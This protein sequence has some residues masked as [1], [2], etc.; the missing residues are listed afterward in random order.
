VGAVGLRL[1]EWLAPAALLFAAEVAERHFEVVELP[2][3]KAQL[4][5]ETV[6]EY[7]VR[8]PEMPAQSDPVETAALDWGI[9]ALVSWA[10][11]PAKVEY[12]AC[13][14]K[15]TVS[16]VP[17]AQSAVHCFASAGCSQSY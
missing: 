7:V 13:G 6:S 12:D 4:G 5:V 3:P 14:H 16:V 17:A 15:P 9:A 2:V 8:V 11:V 1:V 10:A